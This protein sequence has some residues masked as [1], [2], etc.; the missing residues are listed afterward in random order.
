LVEEYLNSGREMDENFFEE[1][2]ILFCEANPEA[3]NNLDI[4]MQNVIFFTNRKNFLR[5]AMNIVRGSG[6][7]TKEFRVKSLDSAPKKQRTFALQIYILGNGERYKDFP[8]EEDCLSVEKLPDGRITL[9]SI[10]IK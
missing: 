10:L 8:A 5:S 3:Q 9:G 2:M 1:S 4:L 7:S 6:F